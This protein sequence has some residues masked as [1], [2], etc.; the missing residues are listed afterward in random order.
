VRDTGPEGSSGFLTSDESVI[1]DG[2]VSHP[3]TA[4]LVINGDGMIF[5]CRKVL[6][7]DELAAKADYWL[8]LAFLSAA[9]V[10][11]VKGVQDDG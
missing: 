2:L 3:N 1:C 6:F 8:L 9:L 10:A 5:L 11:G 4:R 7:K